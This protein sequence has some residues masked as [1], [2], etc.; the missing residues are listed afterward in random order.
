MDE[1]KNV[2]LFGIAILSAGILIVLLINYFIVQ[3]KKASNRKNNTGNGGSYY[4]SSSAPVTTYRD[5]RVRSIS[6]RTRLYL[7]EINRDF[8]DFS[9]IQFKTQT[10]NLLKAYLNSIQN[11]RITDLNFVSPMLLSQ[12]QYE[13]DYLKT[14][15]WQRRFN[16]KKIEKTEIIN[17]TIVNGQKRI[18]FEICINFF[19]Y[20]INKDSSIIYGSREIVR[21]TRYQIEL[22]F[23]P[24]PDKKASIMDFKNRP[25]KCPE[26]GSPIRKANSEKCSVCSASLKE[27]DYIWQY[28]RIAEI[29]KNK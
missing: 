16:D 2:L 12:I 7:A 19:D 5:M 4:S 21:Y 11:C 3:I 14:H 18:T 24:D 1:Q 27:I 26:C 20:T 8:P 28:V 13:I 29:S 25:R 10:E 15:N 22:A 17:Y 6:S 9:Y 23:V